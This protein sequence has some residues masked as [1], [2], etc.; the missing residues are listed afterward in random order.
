MGEEN[1]INTEQE[2]KLRSSYCEKN[3]SFIFTHADPD[4][5]HVAAQRCQI[6]AWKTLEL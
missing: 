1:K 5:L 3:N 6:C 4:A 2:A